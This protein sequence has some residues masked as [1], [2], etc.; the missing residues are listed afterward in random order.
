MCSQ[1]NDQPMI[2]WT[3]DR[4]LQTAF[5][6]NT[7]VAMLQ[8]S[9]NMFCWVDSWLVDCS[10]KMSHR[11]N[12][13]YFCRQIILSNQKLYHS[14]KLAMVAIWTWI[15]KLWIPLPGWGTIGCISD[16]FLSL[17]P[18]SK[19]FDTSTI[20]FR[21][22]RF[23]ENKNAKFKKKSV[24][25]QFHYNSINVCSVHTTYLMTKSICSRC[26]SGSLPI[27]CRCFL[28]YSMQFCKN[29]DATSKNLVS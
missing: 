14:S 13:I 27:N 28:M 4:A 12:E 8:W 6:D 20:W 24:K 17:K 15:G 21:M 11:Q 26:F 22:F 10:Q 5:N 16:D 25:L 18:Q 23:L 7:N 9:E 2:L 1:N 19:S 3:W 29:I